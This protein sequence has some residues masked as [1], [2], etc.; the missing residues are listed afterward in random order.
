MASDIMSITDLQHRRILSGASL[1][2]HFAAVLKIAV[3]RH[4]DRV[5]HATRNVIEC[6]YL[7]PYHR[8]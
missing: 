6:I 1:Y 5:R 3:V 7:L 4:I 2:A 8:L